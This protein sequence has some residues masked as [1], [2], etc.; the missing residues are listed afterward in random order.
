VFLL[1]KERCRVCG[2]AEEQ[3]ELAVSQEESIRVHIEQVT[4]QPLANSD[5]RNDEAIDG[6]R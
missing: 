6:P 5:T 1:L 2:Q 3:K 4:R